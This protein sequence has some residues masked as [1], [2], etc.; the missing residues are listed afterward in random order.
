M[1]IIILVILIL[2]I[3]ALYFNSKTIDNAARWSYNIGNNDAID[4]RCRMH[5]QEL[6]SRGYEVVF[7]ALQGSQNY[8]LD[9]YTDEYQSDV[10]TKAIVLPSFEDIIYNRA[11][12][13]TTIILENNEHI[14]VKDIR[15]M[16]DM[17]KKE[18]ISYIE[19][20]YSK[21]QYVNPKYKALIAP[22]LERREAIAALNTNQFVRCL[23]GMSMEKRKA[24]C[25]PYPN[26]I[27]KIEKYGFDGKQLSHCVRL[28]EFL[29][30]WINNVP[31]ESCYETSKRE[32][33]LNY[34]KQLVAD[35]SRIMTQEEAV[36]ACEY[37][38]EMTKAMKDSIV[39]SHEEKIDT[40]A[41]ELLDNVKYNILKKK[42]KEDLKHGFCK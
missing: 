15:V 26:L 16:F 20:L 42:F 40:A 6:L 31:L 34:K 19:L 41:L 33:L 5:L 37:Y 28:N 13:S 39:G 7:L 10:D 14:D 8:G 9:E 17:F 35:G 36:A 2:I 1:F 38:D 23:A 11:P 32:E 30:K 27:D 21:Y 4:Q 12:I 29:E 25:H 3:L 24:L 22:V 18:N